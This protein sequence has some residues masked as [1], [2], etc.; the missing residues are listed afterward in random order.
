M[1]ALADGS[2]VQA[3]AFYEQ[4]IAEMHNR[5]DVDKNNKNKED[6][7]VAV[8]QLETQL[9]LH[10][11]L[12]TAYSSLE[13]QQ[14]DNFADNNRKAIDHYK[15]TIQ[16]YQKFLVQDS[17][18][19]A[20]SSSSTSRRQEQESAVLRMKKDNCRRIAAQASFFLGMVHQDLRQV[21]PA[22]D[23]YRYA[24]YLDPHH[25]AALANL[26]SLLQ[27]E[28]N[29]QKDALE[30]YNQA[31]RI[32]TS[33]TIEPTD[34]PP[35][36]QYILSQLQY[37]IGICITHDPEQRS[38]CVVSQEDDDNNNDSSSTTGTQTVDCKEMATHAFALA[39][40]YDPDNEN[41]KHML[42]TLTAD[43]TMKRASNQYVRNLFDD[44]ASNFEHS[45]VDELHYNGFERL[46]RGF[47]RAFAASPTLLRHGAEGATTTTAAAAAAGTPM[48]GRVLDA[49]CGTGLVGEQ[50][51]N[52]SQFLMGVDLSPAI[53]RE[54]VKARPHVYNQTQAGD[55]IDVLHD[56]AGSIDLIVAAD[57][58]IYFG[59]LEPLFAAMETGLVLGGYIAFT[60]ENVNHETETSLSSSKPDWR[61]QLT[62]SGRFAHRFECKSNNNKEEERIVGR[63]QRS[64]G[65]HAIVPQ[66]SPFALTHPKL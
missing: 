47:D 42:A 28:L 14:E 3:I 52:I 35:N 43:A 18:K 29:N 64:R 49:G 26:G 1:T 55:L 22:L 13:E 56:Q 61:W 25:W 20:S 2:L 57:S 5:N 40:Q 37:R 44:Y 38:K 36:P 15:T 27:D 53:L 7:G 39:V 23:A 19:S 30:A 60:L 9:S 16:E 59:D 54:A 21:K 33:T 6:E 46:R 10:T 12:A 31:F 58:Y 11:N 66:N 8:A 63:G 51:R 34:P 50:F 65:K 17:T 62:A 41:A 32:L 4:G 45:L 24:Q 48:F